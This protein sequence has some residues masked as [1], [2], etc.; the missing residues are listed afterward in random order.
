MPTVYK[1]IVA[2]SDVVVFA[3]AAAVVFAVVVVV[4]VVIVYLTKLHFFENN[5]SRIFF[6][7]KLMGTRLVLSLGNFQPSLY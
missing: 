3:D 7:G 2:S 4:V 6:N 1:E 5:F